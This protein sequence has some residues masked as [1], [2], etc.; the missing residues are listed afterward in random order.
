MFLAGRFLF[1]AALKLLPDCFKSVFAL[2]FDKSLYNLYNDIELYQSA[3]ALWRHG[4]NF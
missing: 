3:P 1:G 4:F 2:R